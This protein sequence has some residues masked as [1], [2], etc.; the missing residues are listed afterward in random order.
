MLLGAREMLHVFVVPDKHTQSDLLGAR[1]P[2]ERR[3]F[4]FV[5]FFTYIYSAFYSK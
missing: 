5:F 2:S 4:F 1:H 3:F